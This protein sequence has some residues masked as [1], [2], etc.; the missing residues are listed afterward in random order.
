V[1]L[2]VAVSLTAG[3]PAAAAAQTEAS[4]EPPIFASSAR[5]EFLVDRAES[6][7]RVDGALDEAAWT[8]AMRL[9]LPFETSPGDNT[10]ARAETRCHVTYD[11]ANLYLACEAFDPDPASIRAFVTDRDDVDEHD[12]V[13]FT[14]DPFNDTRRAFEFGITALGVQSDGVFD[15]QQGWTDRSWDAIW[16][17]AGRITDSGYIV[18]AAIP[19]RSLRF[20]SSAGIQTWGIFAW[21]QWPRSEAVEFRSM[22]LDRNNSCMLCQ[23]NLATGFQGISPG[24]NLELVPTITSSR[25]DSR[26]EFPTDP[27]ARGSLDA[28]P[29]LDLRWGITSDLTVNT[30]VNPDFSQVEADVAQLDVNNRFALFFPEK[31]PFFLEGADFFSTPLRAVFTRTIADPLVGTKL[32]GKTGANA[33]GTIVARDRTSNFVFPGNQ[34]SSSASLEQDMTTVVARFRR[35]VGASSTLG[36][37]YTGREGDAYHNRVG[38]VDGFLRPWNPLTVQFQYLRAGTDYPDSLAEENDQATRGLG[39]NA[40]TARV[41]YSTRNWLFQ[42]FYQR[43][44]PGF[45]ADAGFINQVDL[46]SFNFWGQRKFWGRPG[47]GFSQ[48]AL[49]GGVWRD[50]NLDGRL[51]TE[52]VWGNIYFEGPLQTFFWINPD[53]VSEF[54]EGQIFTQTRLWSGWGIRPSGNVGVNLQFNTGDAIDFTNAQKAFRLELNPSVDLRLGRH[55]DLRLSHRLQRL[56]TKGTEIFTANLTQ[57]RTVYNFNPRTFV[58]AIVQFRNTDRNPALYG[59][60]VNRGEQNLFTQF[61]F[62]YK[63]NP[64][65]VA[66]LG[67]TDTRLGSTD[68]SFQTIPLRQS[69]RTFFMKL[70]YAWRP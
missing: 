58:R 5:E 47:G 32:T 37:L 41:K 38:G 2:S 43:L 56:S 52:G 40:L 27:L 30:T 10:P 50:E 46:R 17:S 57:V 69:S 26:D 36:V 29:G 13:G 35:D 23:A 25:T 4:M 63:V 65:T 7:I 51:T 6:T 66:F 62:S 18:E 42:G 34:G 15:Q 53:R 39:G 3:L 68:E 11:D 16:T 24:V 20:P 44:D 1:L 19:F 12:R 49:N 28:E 33:V 45:R 60:E 48:I 67:Y 9:S 14:I 8:S 21:R 70:G 61:L 55:V 54:F 31:R 59:D 64:Q 22:R